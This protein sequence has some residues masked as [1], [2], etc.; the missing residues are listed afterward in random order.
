M[1]MRSAAAVWL[2]F[3]VCAAFTSAACRNVD[4]P[5]TGAGGGADTDPAACADSPLE[6]ADPGLEQAVRE[7]IEKPDGDL[8]ADDVAGL[9]E[10]YANNA[11]IS[12]L[13]GIECL[14]SLQ[15]LDLSWNDVADVSRLA[16]L[17]A[18]VGLD[19]QNNA[20]ADVS[21][22]AG[23]GAL[24]DLDLSMNDVV[25]VAPLAGLGALTDL[26][27]AET[28]VEALGPLA[29]LT[30]LRFLDVHTSEVADLAPLVANAGIGAGDRVYADNTAVV[31]GDQQAN[32]DALCGRGVILCPWCCDE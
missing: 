23:L 28:E 12:N 13:R 17:P 20:I 19:L 22:I 7:M 5:D 10:L 26:S 30:A 16:A 18:L 11:E 24:T 3:T 32:I 27:L 21:P 1:P 25:D 6:F 14:P 2:P 15:V 29:G 8:Y 4:E 9:T 31:P